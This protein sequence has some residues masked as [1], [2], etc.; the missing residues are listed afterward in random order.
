MEGKHLL[1][2]IL[3]LLLLPNNDI[4]ATSGRLKGNSITNCN[5]QNY[6]KHGK[7]NHWHAAEKRGDY[8]YANGSPLNENPCQNTSSDSLKPN[9][10]KTEIPKNPEIIKSSDTSLKEIK[11]NYDTIKISSNMKYET[12]AEKI[13]ISVIANDDKATLE[14][15]KEKELEIGTTLYT[16]KVTAENGDVANYE[17]DITRMIIPLSSNKN[18]KIYYNDKELIKNQLNK[19]IENID[20]DYNIEKIDFKY[21][22]NDTKSK[23][24]FFGNNDLKEGKNNIQIIITAQ[25]QSKDIYA[26]TVNKKS[27]PVDISSVGYGTLSLSI[28]GGTI[29]YVAK[30]T[31]K[32]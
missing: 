20:V 18:F 1:L 24:D 17:I 5:G 9:N 10:N 16:I 2:I 13:N 22:L 8:W 23:I 4:F 29:F 12:Y 3:L 30:K 7:D 25:D 32:S 26:L 31:K 27:K 28:I 11:I 15:E 6:G 19:T 14:Y 21:I